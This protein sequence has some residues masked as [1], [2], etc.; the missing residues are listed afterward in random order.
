VPELPEV[1]SLARS[2]P[3]ASRAGRWRPSRSAP[4]A[5]SRPSHPR[6]AT[7]WAALSSGCRGTASG[8]IW[9]PMG[10]TCW[11][12]SRGRAG[13]AGTTPCRPPWSG[14]ASRRSRCGSA[15]Q[16]QSAASRG[17]CGARNAALRADR[18]GR[19]WM[20]PSSGDVHRWRW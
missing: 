9:R 8:S 18:R 16:A 20:R 15:L 2:W 10:H 19:C 17:E 12:T 5:H 4:W 13:S 14:R 6:R 1:E 3:S 11:L 7:W